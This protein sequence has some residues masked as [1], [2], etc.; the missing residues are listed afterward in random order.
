MA[1]THACPDARPLPQ[2]IL[3][4]A[5][6]ADTKNKKQ[7][8]FLYT[9]AI[10]IEVNN[11]YMVLKG[12]TTAKLIALRELLHEVMPTCDE[13]APRVVMGPRVPRSAVWL[14]I[15]L[16]P[17]LHQIRNVITVD[18]MTEGFE[19]RDMDAAP[20]GTPGPQFDPA[21]PPNQRKRVDLIYASAAP[22]NGAYGSPPK[23]RRGSNDAYT[24]SVHAA[25]LVLLSQYIVGF[26]HAA[27][28]VAR[29]RAYQR[30]KPDPGA[31]AS[32]ARPKIVRLRLMPLGGGFFRNTPAWI[33]DAIL[34]AYLH[35]RTQA[36]PKED[37]LGHPL[38]FVEV[39]MLTYNG[40]KFREEG[41]TF[42]KLF[43]N[44]HLFHVA[45]GSAVDYDIT[46]GT[47]IMKERS[48][49]TMPYKDYIAKMLRADKKRAKERA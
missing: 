4:N 47:M 9:R 15:P 12:V 41:M 8:G 38:D 7:L 36:W 34:Q 44:L 46:S 17:S 24:R 21:I 11:G 6:N 42:A 16:A 48:G 28:T 5:Q 35:V 19:S 18:A 25:K 33:R 23:P 31:P 39:T 2:V 30:W 43:N 3:D 40:P 32:P 49:R 27:Q 45:S 20:K 14:S 29:S 37:R 10:P 13:S 26:K 22:A 1:R